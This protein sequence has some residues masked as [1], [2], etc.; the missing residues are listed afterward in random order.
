MV[1]LKTSLSESISGKSKKYDLYSQSCLWGNVCF[2]AG[3]NCCKNPAD[4]S[5]CV[6]NNFLHF[7]SYILYVLW[8]RFN[9]ECKTYLLLVFSETLGHPDTSARPVSVMFYSCY[10]PGPFVFALVTCPSGAALSSKWMLYFLVQME[11]KILQECVLWVEVSSHATVK[12]LA[13]TNSRGCKTSK[14]FCSLAKCFFI[15]Y[16]QRFVTCFSISINS[17]VLTIIIQLVICV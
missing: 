3:A 8:T 15:Y 11:M 7:L 17:D 14:H 1:C 5:V 2:C 6:L 10:E 12:S 4:V 13:T 16:S 9:K